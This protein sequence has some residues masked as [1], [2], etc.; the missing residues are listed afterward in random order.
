M[1][2][3]SVHLKSFVIPMWAIIFCISYICLLVLFI[4]LICHTQTLSCPSLS[5]LAMRV[6]LS[7]IF[8][9]DQKAKY[10]KID[11]CVCAKSFF[12]SNQHHFDGINALNE[13]NC[14]TWGLNDTSLNLFRLKFFRYKHFLNKF[15]IFFCLQFILGHLSDDHEKKTG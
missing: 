14:W 7:L 15:D 8:M 5:Y 3:I 6:V 11:R 13:S 10:E 2:A 1:Q 12:V 4:A 9:Y